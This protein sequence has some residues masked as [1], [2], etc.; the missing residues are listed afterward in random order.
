MRSP[1]RA[2]TP[3]PKSGVDVEVNEG[4]FN[5]QQF[6]SAVASGSPPDAVRMDRNTLGTYASRGALMPLDECIDTAGVDME[7]FRAPAVEQV[8]LDEKVWGLPEFY[9]VRVVIADD[10]SLQSAGLSADA[11]ATGDWAPLPL[12]APR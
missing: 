6:L 3:T 11:V 8:T 9:S 10:S 4:G 2:S 7:A 5:E 1:P 12:P